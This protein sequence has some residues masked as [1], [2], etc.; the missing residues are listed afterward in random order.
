MGGKKEPGKKHPNNVY[1]SYSAEGKSKNK[2][3][4]KCGEGTFLAAHKDRVHCGKCGY[5][6]FSKKE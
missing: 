3:C 1:K 5:T 4:P 2:V 6:E